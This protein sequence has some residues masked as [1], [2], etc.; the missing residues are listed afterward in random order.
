MTFVAYYIDRVWQLA[1]VGT[2]TDLTSKIRPIQRSDDKFVRFAIGKA[3]LE[4]LAIANRRGRSLCLRQLRLKYLIILT[5]YAHPFTLSAWLLLSYVIVEFSSMWPTSQYGFLGYLRPVPIFAACAVPIMFFIDWYIFFDSRNC[6]PANGRFRLNRPI[7]EQLLH[8]VL[9]G[10]DMAD[11]MGYYSRSPGSGFWVLTHNDL[12]VG[13]I[14]VDA[15]RDSTSSDP[16]RK[17]RGSEIEDREFKETTGIATIRHFYVDEAYRPSGV[18]E[19]LLNHAVRFTFTSDNTIK[20]LQASDLSLSPY[21]GKCLQIADFSFAEKTQTLGVFRWKLA[22]RWL[23][24]DA[25]LRT[26]KDGR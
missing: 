13:L 23:D 19:D 9:R 22:V 12:F 10:P 7:F 14:A 4:P 3:C 20:R 15:S 2:M 11:L 1:L 26:L 24:R 5:V 8:D 25:W 21:I 16:P 17:Q 18:Q 6:G